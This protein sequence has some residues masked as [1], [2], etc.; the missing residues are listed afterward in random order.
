MV[1]EAGEDGAA[2]PFV[3]EMASQEPPEEVVAFA[4]KASEPPPVLETCNCCVRAPLP[5]VVVKLTF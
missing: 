1:S 2:V 3:D 4:V 5:W